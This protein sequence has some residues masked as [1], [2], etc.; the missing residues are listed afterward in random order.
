MGDTASLRFEFESPQE[1]EL[2]GEFVKTLFGIQVSA[3]LSLTGLCGLAASE[4][5]QQSGS[6]QGSID[7][8]FGGHCGNTRRLLPQPPVKCYDARCPAQSAA[9]LAVVVSM[10]TTLWGLEVPLFSVKG[11]LL[12]PQVHYYGA[13]KIC[14]RPRMPFLRRSFLRS[15][16]VCFQTTWL[17]AT[18]C[19]LLHGKLISFLHCSLVC[20]ALSVELRDKSLSSD[21][22]DGENESDDGDSRAVP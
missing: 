14:A 8:G 5:F 7:L 22:S 10:A 9:L 1:A 20:C 21:K 17:D 6:L 18:C 4:V 19:F 11:T 12:F 3:C 13:K 15:L 2:F 16:H